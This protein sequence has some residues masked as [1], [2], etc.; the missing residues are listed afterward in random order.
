MLDF[1]EVDK[2][3]LSVSNRQPLIVS[4]ETMA[5]FVSYSY[6]ASGASISFMSWLSNA[7]S[8]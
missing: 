1:G 6:L 3:R 4:V 5:D 2:S 7:I 8:V